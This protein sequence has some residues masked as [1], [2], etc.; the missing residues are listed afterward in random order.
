M[1]RI[2]VFDFDGVLVDSD[3]LKQDAFFDLFSRADAKTC[4]FIKKVI[5]ETP[6][7]FSRFEILKEIFVKMGYAFESI[8]KRVDAY[9]QKYRLIVRNKILAQGVIFGH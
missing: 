8:Q 3:K 9:E 2:I 1:R 4:S 5:S 7:H 6:F